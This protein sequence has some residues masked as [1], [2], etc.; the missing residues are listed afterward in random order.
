MRRF[1][2]LFTA[3]FCL[4]CTVARAEEFNL[5]GLQTDSAAYARSLAARV[6]AGGTPQARRQAEQAATAATR[7]P[8]WAAAATAWEN[9]IAQGDATPAQWLSLAEAQLRRAPPEPNRALQAAWQNFSSVDAGAAEV[10]ALLL[11]ADALKLQDRP[12]QAIQALE[13][14][15]ERAPDDRAIAQRLEEARRAAGILV[16][17][18][19]T[20]PDAEPPRACLS[21]TV[22]PSRRDDFHPGDW[23][24]LEPPVQGAA[25]TREG[26]QI[27][28][29]GLPSGTT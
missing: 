15:A 28:V 7:K 21:F 10:P 11:M 3:L 6:P 5:P 13:A 16:R 18:V 22:P 20:Q 8:D 19:T 2:L 4:V 27:C 12:A 17:R 1:A 29:S 23:V 26:D 14:A 24:R 25:V 9:R